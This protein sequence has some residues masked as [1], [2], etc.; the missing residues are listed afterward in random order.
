MYVLNER[1]FR[2][3]GMAGFVSPDHLRRSYLSATDNI[4]VRPTAKR[5]PPD[6]VFHGGFKCRQP[7]MKH[8]DGRGNAD[9]RLY[10]TRR[11]IIIVPWRTIEMKRDE[12]KRYLP[13]GAVRLASEQRRASEHAGVR[14]F[15]DENIG[16]VDSKHLRTFRSAYGL[17]LTGFVPPW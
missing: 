10:R 16:A 5:L 8:D 15:A 9:D 1:A 3:I 11:L 6:A 14:D 4:S 2:Y 7:S 12:V 17:F 13:V